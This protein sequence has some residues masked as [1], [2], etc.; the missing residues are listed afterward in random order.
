MSKQILIA[1]TVALTFGLAIQAAVVLEYDFRNVDG[2]TVDASYNKSGT[3]GTGTLTGLA[4]VNTGENA[5]MPANISPGI[6]YGSLSIPAA[7]PGTNALVTSG[8]NN[9]WGDYFGVANFG[10]GTIAMVFKPNLNGRPADREWLFASPK[11]GCPTP[12]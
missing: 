7:S 12:R 1:V 8:A 2:T 9:K 10:T 11:P 5:G 6:R 3:S 4:T